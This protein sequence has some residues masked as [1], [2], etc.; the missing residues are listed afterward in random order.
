M[1]QKPCRERGINVYKSAPGQMKLTFKD[2]PFEFIPDPNNRWVRL[3]SLIPW[4][5]LEVLSGY[6]N[7]FGSTGNPALPFR[8]ALGALLVQARL[9]LT[10]EE[11]VEQIKENPYIQ[12]FLGFEGYN[13]GKKP[14][15]PSMMVHFRKR[16]GAETLKILD[17]KIY[18][19]RKELEKAAEAE[20]AA[21]REET[22]RLC[23]NGDPCEPDPA[24]EGAH[25]AV[26]TLPS[27][28]TLILDA[29]CAPADITYPTDLKL[30]IAARESAE[31][32]VDELWKGLGKSG[33]AKP[34]TCRRVASR[35][36][37][38]V[39]KQRNL[40]GKKLRH[41]LKKQLSFLKRD[42]KVIDGLLASLPSDASNEALPPL[43][44]RQMK[45]L[46][47]LRR[48]CDQQ[49]HMLDAG[50]RRVDH[51]I[52]SLSMPHVRPIVRGKAGARVEFGAK[53]LV[54][55]E[56]GHS[57]VVASSWDNFNESALFTEACE[58][59]LKRNGVWPDVVCADMI[60]RTRSNLAWC[61]ERGIRLSGPSLGR[62][63]KDREKAA[64]SKRI[65]R[66]DAS[67]R[68]EVEGKF[69]EA[70]RKYGLDLIRA[71]LAETSESFIV[72]RF[73]I[74]NLWRMLRLSFSF[75][76]RAQERFLTVI[77]RIFSARR[78]SQCFGLG[79]S[80]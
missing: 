43:N 64:E 59:Y 30:L 14:F 62:P 20:R 60:F 23:G 51:R 78:M 44:D 35:H 3:A 32:L 29:T 6:R 56:N 22:D 17:L 13:S 15:D 25:K 7:H 61:K 34:R 42:L 76:L 71:K 66:L 47:T 72:L 80:L 21:G 18:E 65:E 70:K 50:T 9:N 67:R 45:R 36:A 41:A 26:C 58:G 16:L 55:V 27:E 46:E 2:I 19:K 31:K 52:V 11:T 73:M 8:V 75:F 37:V 79:N 48:V 39:R 10:D 4:E 63:P 74:M 12:Y 28:G 69:G 53:L 68:N 24:A 5:E 1:P 49:K 33:E 77:S 57:F 40:G 38:V 54:A